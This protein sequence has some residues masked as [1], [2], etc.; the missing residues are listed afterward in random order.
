MIQRIIVKV[1]AILLALFFSYSCATGPDESS[2][3]SQSKQISWEWVSQCD[4]F[5]SVE[6]DGCLLPNHADQDHR[7]IVDSGSSGEPVINNC[8]LILPVEESTGYYGYRREEPSIATASGYVIEAKLKVESFL[9]QGFMVNAG[10]G[11]SDG[12][13]VAHIFLHHGNGDT[14]VKAPDMNNGGFR[15]MDTSIFHTYRIEVYKTGKARYFID[16][17]LFHEV[18]YNLLNPS[19]IEPNIAVFGGAE[20][21]SHWDYINYQ[22]CSP[23]ISERLPTEDQVDQIKAKVSELDAPSG[24]KNSLVNQV[25]K[26]M[27][28]NTRYYRVNK[29]KQVAFRIFH[30]RSSGVLSDDSTELEAKVDMV[31]SSICPKLPGENFTNNISLTALDVLDGVLVPGVNPLRAR[32]EATITPTGRHISNK[33]DRNF[34]L[35]VRTSI[36]DAQTGDVIRIIDDLHALPEI[37]SAQDRYSKIVDVEWDGYDSDGV[38]AIQGR[39]YHVVSILEY[40]EYHEGSIIFDQIIAS[41]M[42]EW[43]SSYE[44]RPSPNGCEEF[45]W[46]ETRKDDQ[47]RTF[48]HAGMLCTEMR[49]ITTECEVCQ[50]CTLKVTKSCRISSIWS[51]GAMCEDGSYLPPQP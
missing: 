18:D 31:R 32:I 49:E 34:G 25:N 24:I 29:L 41:M 13:K 43:D 45:C 9:P 14:S 15:W 5:F 35:R 51:M 20:S 8:I 46:T 27:E 44:Y 39:W 3:S 36:I 22:I 17:E 2:N 38:E 7:W 19:N 47:W 30:L 16:D 42:V 33:G 23:S 37:I 50:K 11:I 6:Y 28:K 40:V 12:T 26:S 1:I 48:T 4:E 10:F 21:V